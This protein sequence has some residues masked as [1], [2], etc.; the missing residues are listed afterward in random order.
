MSDTTLAEQI[1][2]ILSD[3]VDEALEQSD[4]GR[5][6][7]DLDDRYPVITAAILAL[8]QMRAMVAVMAAIR[9]EPDNAFYDRLRT[10]AEEAGK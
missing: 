1:A 4:D 6:A 10:V 2:A 3:L 9:D 5:N 8:P 7:V